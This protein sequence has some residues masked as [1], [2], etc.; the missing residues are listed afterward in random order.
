MR[1]YEALGASAN[2]NRSKIWMIISAI[3]YLYLLLYL[4]LGT[5][6]PMGMGWVFVIVWYF[7]ENRKQ[8]IYL[9]ENNI[10]YEKK[11]WLIPVSVAIGANT[12][13]YIVLVLLNMALG[14]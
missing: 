1:N 11:G 13:L 12:A 9:Q 4:L 6:I 5:E 8:N 14:N 2:A 10:A 7:C 3:I